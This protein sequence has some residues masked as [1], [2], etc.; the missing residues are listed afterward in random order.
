[1]YSVGRFAIESLRLDSFWLDGF[2]VPQLASIAGLIVAAIGLAVVSR[3]A[4]VVYSP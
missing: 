4:K 3:R 2:R 1:L